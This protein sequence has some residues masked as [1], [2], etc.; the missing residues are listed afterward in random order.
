M[1]LIDVGQGY[2]TVIVP[3]V[4]REFR[5]EWHPPSDVGPFAVLSRG[6]FASV[7][8]AIA[9]AR[10]NLNGTPYSIRF[11]GPGEV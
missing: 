8:D 5:T 11:I 9:W 2:Y 4:P 6:A 1:A 3:F 7:G 10:V